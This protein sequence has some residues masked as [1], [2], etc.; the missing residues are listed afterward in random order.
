MPLRDILEIE[1]EQSRQELLAEL[2]VA[3]PKLPYKDIQTVYRLVK[4]LSGQ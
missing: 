1:H 3:I 2:T 4:V